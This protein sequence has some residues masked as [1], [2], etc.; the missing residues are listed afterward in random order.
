MVR[1]VPLIAGAIL[2]CA[3]ARESARMVQRATAMK[4]V[5][6]IAVMVVI[7]SNLVVMPMIPVTMFTVDRVNTVMMES[8]TP[9][10]IPVM[11]FI[12]DQASTVMMGSVTPSVTPVMMF[13]VD[14]ANTVMTESATERK[15]AARRIPIV[16]AA[17]IAAAVPIF[18]R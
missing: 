16:T 17:T 1:D 14:L 4:S 6:R 2:A 5:Y 3:R 12:V 18:A 10:M 7:A 11:M 9:S 13:I 15:L 8:V